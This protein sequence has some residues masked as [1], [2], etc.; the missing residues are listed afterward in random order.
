[1]VEEPERQGPVQ[2]LDPERQAAEL[3]R[4]GIEVDGVDAALHDVPAQD[5]LE[6]RL[7]A[8]VVGP[9]GNQ[10]V[11]QAGVVGVS[12]VRVPDSKQA[13]EYAITLRLETVVMLER[14]V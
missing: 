6:A 1:M 2:G 4:Q 12:V 10:L 9:A 11:G 3:H 7:E 5:S 13:H 14:G 8:V